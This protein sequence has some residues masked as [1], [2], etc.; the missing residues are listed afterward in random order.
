MVL[1]IFSEIAIDP[2]FEVK[3]FLKVQFILTWEKPKPNRLLASDGQNIIHWTEL[4][5]PQYFVQNFPVR[6]SSPSLQM[7]GGQFTTYIDLV[8]IRNKMCSRL[9]SDN[10]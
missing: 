5:L 9:I 2:Y 7:S 4:L 6:Q 3:K 10:D 1:P 8:G